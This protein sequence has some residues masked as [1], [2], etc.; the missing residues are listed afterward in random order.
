VQI[1]PGGV[2]R[3]PG[4]MRSR[5]DIRFGDGLVPACLAETMIMTAAH[6]FDR[7]SLGASTRTANIAFYLREGERL[8]FEIVTRD[9][10]V[11]EL[12]SAP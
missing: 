6:A 7:R 2:V 12:E 3:P 10:R 11:A 4:A 9:E 8:G 1:V 5:I